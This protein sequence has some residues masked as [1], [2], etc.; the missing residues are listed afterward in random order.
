MAGQCPVRY[1]DGFCETSSVAPSEYWMLAYSTDQ[2]FNERTACL[3]CSW[4]PVAC[5]KALESGILPIGS[6]RLSS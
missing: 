3:P 1:R 2:I 6:A 4:V 5:P